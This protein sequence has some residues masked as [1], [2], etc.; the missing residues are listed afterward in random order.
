M[1]YSSFLQAK[2][3]PGVASQIEQAA[4]AQG[5]TVSEWLRQASR[6]VLQLQGYDP[7][8]HSPRDAGA[9]YDSLNDK[10]R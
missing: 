6:T 1:A 10:Q 5:T 2:Y 8:P 3:D 4:R 7:A 9:L